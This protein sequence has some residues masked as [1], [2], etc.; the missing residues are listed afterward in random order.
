MILII[1]RKDKEKLKSTERFIR[2]D[3][4]FKCHSEWGKNTKN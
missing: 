3:I 1:T 2:N 4:G